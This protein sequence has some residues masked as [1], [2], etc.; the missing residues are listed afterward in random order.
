MAIHHRQGQGD[1]I[2]TRIFKDGAIR[3][4]PPGLEVPVEDLFPP[5]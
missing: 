2:E 3:L 1:V 5:K 4:D